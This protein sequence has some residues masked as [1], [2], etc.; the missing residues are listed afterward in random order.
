VRWVA[1]ALL[2]GGFATAA[3][4]A[5]R[6]HGGR[7]QMA[8]MRQIYDFVQAHFGTPV[9]VAPTMATLYA[10]SLISSRRRRAG[11]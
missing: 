1:A 8:P 5:P 9:P 6:G 11:A 4:L 10:I 2:A 3:M 7:P